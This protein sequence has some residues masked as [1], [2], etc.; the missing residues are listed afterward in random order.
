MKTLTGIIVGVSLLAGCGEGTKTVEERRDDRIAL[1][2][3]ISSTSVSQ[4]NYMPVQ[5]VSYDSLLAAVTLFDIDKDGITDEVWGHGF[6]MVL[7]RGIPELDGAGRIILDPEN[8]EI[9]SGEFYAG[10]IGRLKY[11][12]VNR[13]GF[14]PRENAPYGRPD[15]VVMHNDGETWLYR[16]N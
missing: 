14:I 7:Y 2:S 5:K 1:L 3:N 4:F 8:R 12:G 9:R 10:V 11:E 15:I 16:N 13:T 6:D